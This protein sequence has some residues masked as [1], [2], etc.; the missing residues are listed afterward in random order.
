M[1]ER[2]KLIGEEPR[3]PAGKQLLRVLSTKK[4][5]RL[6]ETVFVEFEEE[7]QLVSLLHQDTEVFVQWKGG[8]TISACD[9]LALPLHERYTTAVLTMKRALELLQ[10]GEKTSGR[11]ARESAEE[12]RQKRVQQG[13]IA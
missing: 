8:W 10:T 4:L 13:V 9:E 3:T 6:Q 7:H 2:L 12:Q 1:N 11:S 5:W